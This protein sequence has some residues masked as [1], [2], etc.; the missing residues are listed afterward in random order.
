LLSL[1]ACT[2]VISLLSTGIMV[3]MLKTFA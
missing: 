1:V 2:L 3:Y